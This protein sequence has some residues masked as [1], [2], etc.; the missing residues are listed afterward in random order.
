MPTLSQNVRFISSAEPPPE[1][2]PPGEFLAWFLKEDLSK[3]GWEVSAPYN[4]RDRG[5]CLKC[6]QPPCALDV[7]I[8]QMVAGPEWLVQICPRHVPG[9]FERVFLRSTMSATH[10]EVHAAARDVHR[11]LSA[12]G[13]ADFRWCWN[14]DP[15]HGS[16]TAEPCEW[17]EP[18]HG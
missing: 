7:I 10:E 6:C 13:F 8:V 3:R 18:F 14:A 15:A 16:N 4:W 17:H 5:W 9:W 2:P 1:E 11:V 12:R